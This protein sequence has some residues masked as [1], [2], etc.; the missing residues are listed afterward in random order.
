MQYALLYLPGVGITLGSVRD[1]AKDRWPLPPGSFGAYV[2]TDEPDVLHA[3]AVAAGAQIIT[4]NRSAPR[5]LFV[6][7]L[8]S[9]AAA[10]TGADDGVVTIASSAFRPFTPV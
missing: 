8:Y 4:A 1:H 10:I 3:R 7:P 9:R 5:A 6:E 2:V